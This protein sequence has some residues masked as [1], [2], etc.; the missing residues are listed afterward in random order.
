LS[1]DAKVHYYTGLPNC[2]LFLSTFEFVMK[3][4]CHGEKCDFY[5][6]SFIIVFLKL[7]LNLGMQDIAYRLDVS[8]V[9][10]SRL[11]HASLDVMMIRLAWLIMAREGRV[12]EDHA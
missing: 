1:D 7:W 10:V 11:F 8:L 6:R 3:P 9:T 5:W 2:A 4:F 12:M